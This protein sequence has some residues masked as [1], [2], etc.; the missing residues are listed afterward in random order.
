ML[1]PLDLTGRV[2]IVTGASSGIGL[3]TAVLLS[4]LGAKLV[5]VAR[6]RER[7]ELAHAQLTGMEHRVE[8]FDF[9]APGV[10]VA[11]WMKTISA[12]T[13]PIGG[14]VHCAGVQLIKPVRLLA[15]ADLDA[16]MKVNVSAALLLAKGLRVKGVHAKGASVVFVSSVMGLVGAAGRTAYCASKG[17]LGAMTKALALELAAEDIRVNCVAPGFVRTPMLEQSQATVGPEQMAAVEKLHPLG[18]GEPRDI[19]NAVAY[20]VADTGRWVTGTTLVVDGGYTAQ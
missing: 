20:L 18:F 7:L 4:Q 2:V 16:I 14:I 1:N 11:A 12:Q 8:P 15:E 10:D 13:G 3:A 17:A 19:A 6:S 9:S 5:L